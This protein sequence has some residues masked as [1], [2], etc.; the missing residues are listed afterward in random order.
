MSLCDVLQPMSQG[1]AVIDHFEIEKGNLQAMM[2]GI[3]PGKY[4]RLKING[5]VMMSDTPME[6][7]T[8]RPFIWSCFGDVLVG[9]LGIGM[10][11][12]EIQDKEDVNSVTVVEKSPDVIEIVGEQ[13][14]LNHKVTILQGDVFD[15]KPT[16]KFDVIYMDIW[17][18]IN[19]DVYHEEMKPLI[20]RYR[21]YLK[22]KNENP[23]R[24]VSC[25]A[26]PNAKNYRPLY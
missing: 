23:N 26:Q 9:G 22:P 21:R 2:Q 5:S 15:F 1:C 16:Q 13:L 12:M 7:R 17:D 3:P 4:T 6:H 11:L 20:A 10:V 8:N 19:S 24:H 25:W 18:S 14:P